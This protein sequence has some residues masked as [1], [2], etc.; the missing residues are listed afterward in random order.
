M[1]YKKIKAN[2]LK[3]IVFTVDRFNLRLNVSFLPF[4][5]PECNYSTPVKVF[6]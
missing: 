4:S 3:E 1:N 2:G 5:A 6:W